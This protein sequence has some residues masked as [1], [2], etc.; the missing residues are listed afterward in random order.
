MEELKGTEDLIK[1]INPK[2][3]VLA[4]PLELTDA[5][6]VENFFQTVKDRFGVADVLVN[7]AGV[8]KAF[9]E[10]IRDGNLDVWWSDIVGAC[11]CL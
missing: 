6:S 10:T 2:I 9:Q 7:N 11:S 4:L 1:S 8:Q 3:Q 5:T